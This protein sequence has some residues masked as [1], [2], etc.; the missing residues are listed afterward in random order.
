MRTP[1]HTILLIAIMSFAVGA[2]TDR[3]LMRK[4]M[5]VYAQEQR[6]KPVLTIGSESVSVGMP[7]DTVVA[8]FAGKYNLLPPDLPRPMVPSPRTSLGDHALINQVAGKSAG[9]FQCTCNSC[10][11]C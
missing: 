2:T 5:T 7:K 1:K 8:K 9:L 11:T 6:L 10:G 3:L 4:A